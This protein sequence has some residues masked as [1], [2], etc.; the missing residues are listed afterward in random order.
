MPALR[1]LIRINSSAGCRQL[2]GR[3]VAF[4]MR[5]FFAHK[6][7]DLPFP[8]LLARMYSSLGDNVGYDMLPYTST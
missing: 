3:V 7:L 1:L 5:R 2:L 8:G 6:N 4:D